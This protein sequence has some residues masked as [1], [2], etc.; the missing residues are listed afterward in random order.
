MCNHLS[1]APS[2]ITVMQ[3]SLTNAGLTNIQLPSRWEGGMWVKGV[4]HSISKCI[5]M[6]VCTKLVTKFVDLEPGTGAIQ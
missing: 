6:D 1:D 4:G 2:L 3:A 5:Y